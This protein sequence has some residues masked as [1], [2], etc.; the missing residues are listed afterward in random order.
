MRT[1]TEILRSLVA[2]IEAMQAHDDPDS[3]GGFAESRTNDD[4]E[5]IVRWPN[6]RI[7]LDE[8]KAALYFETKTGVKT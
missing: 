7:L 5:P 3:F 6:L 1:P 8:A 4:Y 2:D